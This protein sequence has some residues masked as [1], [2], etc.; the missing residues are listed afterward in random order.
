MRLAATRRAVGARLARD[1]GSARPGALP[2]LRAGATLTEAYCEALLQAGIRAVYIDDELSQGIEVTPALSESTR[3]AAET[4]LERAFCV[5]P[6]ALRDGSPLPA[7]TLAELKQV[8][9]LIAAEVAA[10]DDAVVALSDLAAA[11]AYTLQHSIDV[12]ALGLLL[13]RR[14]FRDHGRLDGRARHS[15]S[16]GVDDALVRL[17]V[18]LLLH[19]VGKLAVPKE[20]LDKPAPLDEHE[21]ELVR[22]HPVLGVDLI[23]TDRISYHS[24]AVIRSHHERWDGCGYP[25]R[26]SGE[27]IPEFARIASVADVYDAVTSE[28]PYRAAA[29]PAAG[30][31]TITAGA[32]TMFDPEVVTAFRRVVAP[33]PPG[34]EVTLLDGR[35]ALVAEV[36]PGRLDRPVIRVFADRR[37]RPLE[38]FELALL[39]HPELE[40]APVAPA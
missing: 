35:R 16:Q 13:A 10:A 30:Y 22:L 34:T 36:P 39:D 32:G 40:L 4:A 19:D 1:V 18:G 2:L 26:L 29:S 38:P 5:A 14:L 24:K 21:W 31:A 8:A 33:Y 37:G 9:K 20:I 17:G 6:A 25:D 7:A 12:A 11:D 28:R 15:S 27:R 23:A 3:A